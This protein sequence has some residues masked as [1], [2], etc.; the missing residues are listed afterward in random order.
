MSAEYYR[1]KGCASALSYKDPKAAYRWLEQAFGFEPLFAI[2][3]KEGNLLHSEMTF[4]QSVIM[5][6]S[7][8]SEKHKSP[9]SLDGL[10]TQTVHVQLEEDVD[11]HC[12]R[13]RKSGAVILME[14]TDQFYGDRAYRAADPEGHIWSFAQ[15][16]KRMTPTEWDAAGGCI[17][18]TRLE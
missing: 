13:A 10:N 5:V 11:A 7:E 12:E 1:P 15:T 14:P 4:G 8:W 16:K 17:T 9:L 18:K 2:L 6:G 3:D